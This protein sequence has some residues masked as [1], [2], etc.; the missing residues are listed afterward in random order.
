MALFPLE[1]KAWAH[2]AILKEPYLSLILDLIK[3]IESRFLKTRSSP[4]L[5]VKEND[6]IYLKKSGGNILGKALVER[7]EYFSGLTFEKIEALVE[8]Y[9]DQLQIR[10]DFLELK[11]DSKYAILIWLKNVQRIAPITYFQKGQQA[12]IVLHEN[13]E[14]Q[15]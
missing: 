15:G 12:W 11:K 14:F 8:R 3:T 4:W 7:V 10:P 6:L 5:K 1:R 2:V 13:I 9:R